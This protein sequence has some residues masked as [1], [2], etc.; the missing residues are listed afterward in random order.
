[1]KLI[2]HELVQRAGGLQFLL[3]QT[4]IVRNT[5]ASRGQA[6]HSSIKHVAD[7]FNYVV[8]A[9]G[10]LNDVEADGIQA[11]GFGR[12][13]PAAEKASFLDGHVNA[14]EHFGQQVVVMAK[15]EQ[16]R[17]GVFQEL[18]RRTGGGGVSYTNAALHPTTSRSFG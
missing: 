15:F 14:G 4:P 3:H 6:V 8:E 13:A 11:F 17:V 9:L 12:H 2:D 7:E 10:Q 5:D 18:Q 1:M 16:L